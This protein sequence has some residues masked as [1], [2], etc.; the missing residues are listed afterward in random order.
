MTFLVT[1][2]NFW[3]QNDHCSIQMTLSCIIHVHHTRTVSAVSEGHESLMINVQYVNS[4]YLYLYCSDIPV[5]INMYLTVNEL[6]T[7]IPLHFITDTYRCHIMREMYPTS[8]QQ[9]RGYDFT[10][11]KGKTH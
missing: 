9:V 5:A 11:L 4:K 10:L 1:K 8:I 2:L 7:N 6:L 3:E